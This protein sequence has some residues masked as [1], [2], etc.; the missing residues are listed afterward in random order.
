MLLSRPLRMTA[1]AA[2][3]VLSLA[4]CSASQDENPAPSSDGG[5]VE[6][7]DPTE[8]SPS[9]PTDE[10]SAPGQETG[11]LTITLDG[12]EISFT[13]EIVRC[14]GEPGTIRNAVLTMADG[15][16]PLIEVTPGEFVMV[17]LE[18]QGEPEKSTSP[19]RILAED[20]AISFDGARIGDA[21]VEGT[22]QCQPGDQD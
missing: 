14:D 17:K 8:G 21:V 9:E 3:L 11:T 2:A 6:A 1:A 5:G 20:D 12:E 13:P 15:E 4:A 22:V 19:E 10:P 18:R 7:A 16:L